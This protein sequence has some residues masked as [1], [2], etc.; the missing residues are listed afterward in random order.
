[1][2]RDVEEEEAGAAGPAP[3]DASPKT[4]DARHDA[5]PGQQRP[6]D[7]RGPRRS[8]GPSRGWRG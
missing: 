1:L 2:P 6:G 7:R 4:H 8:T 3:A 5:Q